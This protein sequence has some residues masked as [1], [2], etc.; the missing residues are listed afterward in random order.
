VRLAK[1]HSSFVPVFLSLLIA[2]AP[3][4]AGASPAQ[5][6][7]DCPTKKCKD[8]VATARALD[9]KK[10][11][12]RAKGIPD[13]LLELLDKF[14]CVACVESAPERFG[15]LLE[16]AP[17]NRP[18]TRR[19]QWTHEIYT[20]TPQEE[21]LARKELRE[22]KI[23]AF[24]I[25]IDT[26]G[27]ACC[28]DKALSERAGWDGTLEMNTGEMLVFKTAADL[29]ADPPELQ[30]VPADRLVEVP[31]IGTYTKPPKRQ[32]HALCP[33]CEAEANA[34]NA[35]A[36][37]LDYLWGLKVN[38]QRGIDITDHAI[39]VREN[40]IAGLEYKQILNP[41]PGTQEQID[42]LNKINV[43]QAED[44]DKDRRKL[45][46]IEGRIRDTDAQET[47]ALARLVECQNKRC[48]SAAN[49]TPAPTHSAESAPTPDVSAKLQNVTAQI[50][51]VVAAIRGSSSPKRA[52]MEGDIERLLAGLSAR[53]IDQMQSALTMMIHDVTDE[54]IEPGDPAPLSALKALRMS[55]YEIQI[56][57]LPA[58]WQAIARQ[59][60]QAEVD[61]MASYT[62]KRVLLEG[63]FERLIA[64][65]NA[66]SPDGMQTELNGL[67]HDVTR[68]MTEG[69]DPQPLKQLKEI[70]KAIYDVE[71]AQLPSDWR[72]L[73]QQIFDLD[74]AVNSSYSSARILLEGSIDG[75]IAGLYAQSFEQI[76]ANINALKS[77]TRFLT[78]APDLSILG[79]LSSIQAAV[80]ALSGK[81]DLDLLI[82]DIERQM[83]SADSRASSAPVTIPALPPG[84]SA[85][86]NSDGSAAVTGP[87]GKQYRITRDASGGA[88]VED[89]GTRVNYSIGV[90]AAANAPACVANVQSKGALQIGL[91]CQ[92]QSA[93]AATPPYVVVHFDTIVVEPGTLNAGA[94][95]QA[96][97]EG[98][99]IDYSTIKYDFP[100][101]KQPNSQSSRTDFSISGIQL[102]LAGLTNAHLALGSSPG[103]VIGPAT[104]TAP[105][106]PGGRIGEFVPN[107]STTPQAN[108][109][110]SA[111]DDSSG[112]CVA[113]SDCAGSDSCMDVKRVCTGAGGA[114]D[115]GAALKSDAA[116]QLMMT[117]GATAA[118]AAK[119]SDDWVRPW[120]LRYAALV[121]PTANGP[122][123]SFVSNGSSTG[124]A[125]EL[126]VRDPSGAVRTVALPEGLVLE[127]V[128]QKAPD[129]AAPSIAAPVDAFCL[130]F[131]K[132][133]PQTGMAY[134]VAGPD[135]QAK[136]ESLG[137]I[138]SAGR[139]L[140]E[141]GALHPDS[142]PKAYAD[143]IRQY[144][145][146]VQLEHWTMQQFS[147]AF[148]MRTKENA[149]A[150]HV[151][152]TQQMENALRAAAP[153]RWRDISA[154]ISAAAQ[155]GASMHP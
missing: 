153:G 16:Y 4:L 81:S 123:I 55:L 99:A 154:V 26:Q 105:V 62:G 3:V 30:A 34:A 8:P 1:S 135:L 60:Y 101:R 77:D 88:V 41:Q 13:R 75:L 49:A 29:G 113:E 94:T 19:D 17:G 24:Y 125:F 147:D 98:V 23:T 140:A 96:P 151:N 78:D 28:G 111:C 83:E 148:V 20:W 25:L 46:G 127:P 57:E 89:L 119:T 82:E 45:D 93:A 53:S 137:N 48:G 63:G 61:A 70:K 54:M 10:A 138:L 37:T 43:A 74:V 126:Q 134:R 108:T 155:H 106:L 150:L 115:C 52:L 118:P 58:Q 31:P 59:I 84:Y 146:W 21:A 64:Y 69:G 136:Y 47:T 35:L 11:T 76:Q 124:L 87:T 112:M 68:Y 39:A 133:P 107:N 139:T 132:P 145:L 85:T 116:H 152:W 114:A 67:M 80:N 103:T 38:L 131:A 72:A 42:E 97:V 104:W 5:L 128:Q 66:Q 79:P 2:L 7:G 149:E 18:T 92:G 117:A 40:E 90:P 120:S 56:A 142:D 15:I 109:A 36:D 44:L 22:G 143:A 73:A 95:D 50:N 129:H 65:L 86:P 12:M 121:Q 14:E 122:S 144:A 141:S 110:V 102:A 33:A 27:C 71:L 51:Q 91:S 9:A 6:C 100:P 130:Q 32:A